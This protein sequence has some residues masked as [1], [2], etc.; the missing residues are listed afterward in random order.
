MAAAVRRPPGRLEA[1]VR[2]G[3]REL[4]RA[5][6]AAALRARG[7]PRRLRLAAVAGGR[8]PGRP[9]GAADSAQPHRPRRLPRDSVQLS[10]DDATLDLRGPRG[11]ECPGTPRPP[12][13]PPPPPVRPSA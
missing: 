9:G 12:P 2:R 1:R 6:P 8:G 11:P 3:D 13:P 4:S 7:H 5:A 10:R